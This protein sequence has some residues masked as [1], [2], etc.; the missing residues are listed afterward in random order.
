VKSADNIVGPNE[1]LPDWVLEL[2]AQIKLI[3]PDLELPTGVIVGSAMPVDAR[4]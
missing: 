2:A 1:K 3:P 4:H